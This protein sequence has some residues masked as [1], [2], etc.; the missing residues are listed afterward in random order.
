MGR[1]YTILTK[2]AATAFTVLACAALS[3]PARAQSSRSLLDWRRIGNSSQLLGLPSPAGGAADRVWF[4]QDG[5]ILVR[6]SNGRVYVTA[7]LEQ[8]QLDTA[9][10]PPV[11]AAPAG[12]IAP[13]ISA[14][15]VAA[16]S[17]QTVVY[18]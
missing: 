10:P 4:G 8:W 12:A 1:R 11:P 3:V 9:T 7:D 13:E 2:R 17:N 18:A 5:R 16:N 15:L 6:L 14:R